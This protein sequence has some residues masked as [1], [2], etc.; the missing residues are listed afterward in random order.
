MPGSSTCNKIRLEGKFSNKKPNS[1]HGLRIKTEKQGS[2][3]LSS[4]NTFIDWAS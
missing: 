3:K 4:K 2:Q 1:V